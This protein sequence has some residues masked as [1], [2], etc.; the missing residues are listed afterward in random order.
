M[1]NKTFFQGRFTHD[2]E[3]KRTPSG[4]AV[5]SFSLAVDRDFKNQSG[6]KETDF[7][8]FVA[9]KNNAEFVAKW[10]KKG[11]MAIVEGHLQMRDWTDKQGNK[12][13]SAEVIV[14]HIYFG[15]SK[16]ESTGQSD[17]HPAGAAVDVAYDGHSDFSEI[18]EED[19]ELPF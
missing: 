8:P 1:L 7:I 14:D 17:F 3:L 11:S 18:G 6:E 9:W 15:D 12:R 10:F 19:G 13:R 5:T 16:R 2:P 4:I